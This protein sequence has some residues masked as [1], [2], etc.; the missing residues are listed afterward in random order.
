MQAVEK[1]VVVVLADISGYTRFMTD[2]QMSAIHGQQYITYLIESLLREVD[3]PLKLQEI[4]GDALFLYAEDP[5]S[6]EE[7]VAVLAQIPAMLQRFFNAFYQGTVLGAEATPCK[8]AVCRNRDE[9]AL[10]IIVHTGTAVFHRIGGFDKVSGPDVILAH[11]LLKNTV[12]DKEYLLMSEAAYKAIGQA[13]DGPFLR[14]KES[15]DGFADVITF[16]RFNGDIKEQHLNS[17]YRLPP[18]SLV[19]RGQGYAISAMASFFPALVRQL[20]SPAVKA[21]WTSQLG[22]AVMGVLMFP[23][24]AVMYMIRAPRRLLTHRLRHNYLPI[25][26]AESV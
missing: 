10:K 25:G 8:C 19:M 4:E 20:R 26:K 24:M 17:L 5:G 13:M 12:P 22:F 18:A 9:L 11:R 6:D 16:V 21:P 14:G 15:Y 1:R 2:S 3:V 23:V 7:W